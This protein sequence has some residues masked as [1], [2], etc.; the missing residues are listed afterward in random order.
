MS[1]GAPPA[2]ILR[3]A[4]SPLTQDDKMLLAPMAGDSFRMT[5]REC[6]ARRNGLVGRV[7]LRVSAFF[8]VQSSHGRVGVCQLPTHRQQQPTA[9]ARGV[10]SREGA[11]LRLSAGGGESRWSSHRLRQ[12]KLPTANCSDSKAVE[13]LPQTQ[14][15]LGQLAVGE[16]GPEAFPIV[17]TLVACHVALQHSVEG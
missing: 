6:A 12:R 13:E 16:K 2:Q 5:W 3:F 9:V 11:G 7:C 15:Q 4:A 10:V 1:A 14:Q 8:C 17:A